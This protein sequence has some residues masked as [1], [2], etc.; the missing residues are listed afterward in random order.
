MFRRPWKF[1]TVTVQVR[2]RIIVTGRTSP[3][4]ITVDDEA[5]MVEGK[6][7]DVQ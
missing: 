3:L 2:V 6:R 4:R 5:E 7:V 1:G